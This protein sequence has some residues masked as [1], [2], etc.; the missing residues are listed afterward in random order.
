MASSRSP[1]HESARHGRLQPRLSA[2]LA[3]VRAVRDELDRA[4]ARQT[5]P[6]RG[7]AACRARVL[8]QWIRQSE[9]RRQL[10]CLACGAE[11]GLLEQIHLEL[12]RQTAARTT[13]RALRA[14]YWASVKR[15]SRMPGAGPRRPEMPAPASATPTMPPADL[16][17]KCDDLRR[18][19]RRFAPHAGLRHDGSGTLWRQPTHA[20]CRYRCGTCDTRWVRRVPPFEPFAVWAVVSA[21]QAASMPG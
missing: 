10:I 11:H 8:D 4:L 7:E 6:A 1:A 3:E 19:I 5:L 16:C 17:G 13:D 18:D 2:L 15:C 20:E 9:G 21:R 12:G 14:L